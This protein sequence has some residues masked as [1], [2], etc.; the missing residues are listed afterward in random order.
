MTSLGWKREL[1]LV[2]AVAAASTLLFA[3]RF[4]RPVSTCVAGGAHSRAQAE[5]PEEL[6]DRYLDAETMR[7]GLGSAAIGGWKSLGD[8][9]VVDGRAWLRTTHKNSPRYYRVVANRYFQSNYFVSVPAAREPA[10]NL[11]V[12]P[13]TTL[14]ALADGLARRFPA[15]V[16]AAGYARFDTLAS[17]A[18]AAPAVNGE[19]IARHAARYYT[20]PMESA[21]DTLAYVVLLTAAGGNSAGL[22][23]APV[24]KNTRHAHLAYALRL[25]TPPVDMTRPPN[26][27]TVMS[28]GQV[29]SGSVFAEAALAL[30]PITRAGDC[31]KNGY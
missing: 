29:V 23:P 6:R 14:R 31:R 3:P 5:V 25:R 11:M 13:G 10:E 30:Y 17:I 24:E 2:L 19:P 22:L 15:G 26:E 4:L 28:L 12:R 8:A 18:I 7:V 27:Q 21:R 16:I 9:L 1:G 20:R